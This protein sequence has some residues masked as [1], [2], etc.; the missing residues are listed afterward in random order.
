MTPTITIRYEN[1]DG[2][3]T[4]ASMHDALVIAVA[5]YLLATSDR[6]RAAV[7]L[8]L[9]SMGR[10]ADRL[11]TFFETDRLADSICQAA[12]DSGDRPL[13]E[14]VEDILYEAW[15]GNPGREGL[16]YLWNREYAISKDGYRSIS[17]DK[18][19]RRRRDA[20]FMSFA[21]DMDLID[22]LLV[23][24]RGLEP[25]AADAERI[26]KRLAVEVAATKAR[27]QWRRI[28]HGVEEGQRRDRL[29]VLPILAARMGAA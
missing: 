19:I 20:P 4:L 2:E 25:Y 29:D 24:E 5:Y 12:D 26:V 1:A 9:A 14:R 3:V 28:R 8:V 21:D 16:G 22:I 18:D 7:L 10:R 13:S 23:H 27:S 15:K 11:L 6:D 17:L